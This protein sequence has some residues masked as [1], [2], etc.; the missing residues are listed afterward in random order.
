MPAMRLDGGGLIRRALVRPPRPA[1]QTTLLAEYPT[2][3][4]K[5]ADTVRERLINSGYTILRCGDGTVPM[6]SGD[7][8]DPP[9][10]K[11]RGAWCGRSESAVSSQIVIV[12]C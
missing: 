7:V 9:V 12:L 10:A 8:V 6:S 1:A 3:L 11:F 5:V 4:A 2:R